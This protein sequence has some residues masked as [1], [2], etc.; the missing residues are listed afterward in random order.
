MLEQRPS[1][2]VANEHRKNRTSKRATFL[3]Q[4]PEK[5]HRKTGSSWVGAKSMYSN[6]L[7]LKAEADELDTPFK[8]KK[9]KLPSLKL[10]AGKLVVHFKF[11]ETSQNP[12]NK[13]YT[14]SSLH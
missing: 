11:S 10:T 9:I 13:S 8:T 2:P 6:F 12:F 4:S 1:S 3:F 5:A 14:S 7:W